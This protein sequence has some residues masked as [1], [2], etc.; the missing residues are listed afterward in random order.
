M[1]PSQR[2]RP[3]QQASSQ[4][5]Q[6]ADDI[7]VGSQSFISALT[8]GTT[9]TNRS[10]TSSSMMSNFSTASNNNNG[11]KRRNN[12][13]QRKR[14]E[15][16]ST[17]YDNDEEDTAYE[18]RSRS[19]H[20][21]DDDDDNDNMT[22]FSRYNR[23]TASIMTANNSQ[24]KNILTV[25][26]M[27]I[28]CVA[29]LNSSIQ[30]H[31]DDYK[32][33][34]KTALSLLQQEELI[35]QNAHD[36]VVFPPGMMRGQQQ[37]DINAAEDEENGTVHEGAERNLQWKYEPETVELRE[38][39]PLVHRPNLDQMKVLSPETNINIAYD[40]P[41]NEPLSICGRP[42]AVT[43]EQDQQI[44]T[45]FQSKC[46]PVGP[47]DPILL[48]EG[49]ETFGRTGNNLIE[50]LHAL[51]RAQNE[52]LTVGIMIDSWVLPVITTMW[53]AIQNN[54]ME[55]WR[56]H[57]ENTF[58]IKMLSRD[59]LSIYTN[60]IHMET[61]DLFMY[62]TRQSLPD[63]VEFQTYHIRNL[64]RNYNTGVGV[65]I[66]NHNVNDMCTGINALFGPD[67]RSSQKYSVIHS[68]NLEGYAGHELLG[69]VAKNSGC[70][71]EAA[72]NM[73]PEYIKAILE[74]IGML[75][76]P[77][78]F[79]T[80]HQRPE[81]LKRL[82]ADKDIG[83]MIHLV[84]YEASWVGGDITLGIMA[85]AFIGNPASTFSGFI[86]KSR[87]ALGFEG[88]YLFRA[89]NENGEWEE[90]CEKRCVFW[91]RMLWNMA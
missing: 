51:E 39:H 27:S 8:T 79:L 72:L 25:F 6:Y 36:V 23:F 44:M 57:M 10:T 30:L 13:H 40:K 32:S 45:K 80:D 63:Y 50:F 73:E 18:S 34:K 89:K 2:R 61:R 12:Y 67:K 78:V 4:E 29:I 86:A 37:L 65:N 48:I 62:K 58:C 31:H 81:I 16:M 54:D 42:A 26:I 1:T 55:G 71:P 87:L 28:C 41:P 33:S 43:P 46:K 24:V 19:R 75:N 22:I 47:N 90:V 7:T 49:V 9:Y 88:N 35:S 14:D 84:P 77:I 70:D 17:I 83:P 66:R 3:R 85:D 38:Q 91:K 15:D 68:Q 20:Y 76:H 74:P 21:R 69:R 5:H 11:R 59:E 52:G 53:M 64:F 82:R 60:I 56:Q